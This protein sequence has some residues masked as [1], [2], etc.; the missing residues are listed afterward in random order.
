MQEYT[1]LRKG[2]AFWFCSGVFLA[3][4]CFECSGGTSHRDVSIEHTEQAFR[5]EKMNIFVN[6]K[7]MFWVFR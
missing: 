2:R 3:E 1:I 4:M 5:W 6:I 7:N